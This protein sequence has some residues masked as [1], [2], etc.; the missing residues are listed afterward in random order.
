MRGRLVGDHGVRPVVGAVDREL[1]LAHIAQMGAGLHDGHL[2][3]VGRRHHVVDDDV[4][5]ARHDRVDAGRARGKVL[6]VLVVRE[7]DHE[8]AALLAQVVGRGARGGDGI[9]EGQ[10]GNVVGGRGGV[11]VL[12]DH[13]E[14]ANLDGL[15]GLER[16][17]THH[18]RRREERGAVRRH[19][20][21]CQHRH[22]LGEDAQL[23][24]AIAP[25]VVARRGG[26]VARSG[27]QARHALAV[28]DRGEGLPV[29]GVAGVE[30]EVGIDALGKPGHHGVVG[31]RHVVV[32]GQA[33]AAVRVVGVDDG[34][35]PHLLGERR[36]G[37]GEQ[38]GEQSAAEG[39]DHA[40]HVMGSFLQTPNIMLKGPATLPS[41]PERR[42]WGDERPS[43]SRQ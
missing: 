22:Q 6:R 17:V 14:H 16:H 3:P 25:I 33:V 8:L 20:V 23:V 36:G 1:E 19:H 27:H 24:G 10:A 34:D 35:G 32:R 37:E 31:H 29:E 42:P 30:H 26:V 21:G 41:P 38:G 9:R 7:R 4:L 43:P 39:S 11:E 13:A 40:S 28:H 18:R 2:A 12:V 5:V 15:A